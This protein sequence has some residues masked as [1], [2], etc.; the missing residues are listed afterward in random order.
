[1][2][3]SVIQKNVDS[4]FADARTFAGRMSDTAKYIWVGSFGLFYTAM[5]ADKPPLSD[6]YHLNRHKLLIAAVLGVLAFLCDAL[7]N[8]RGFAFAKDLYQFLLAQVAARPQVT[9]E[10]AARN[11]DN[12]I[13]ALYNQRIAASNEPKISNKLLIASQLCA[14]ASALMILWAFARQLHIL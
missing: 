10:G 1:M 13:I 3:D 8:Y 6:F 14:A 11:Q 7:K 2:A 4:N 12:A 9:D 5:M